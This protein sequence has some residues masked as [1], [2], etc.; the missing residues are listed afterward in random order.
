MRWN[1]RVK[2]KKIQHSRHCY[3]MS[4]LPETVHVDS[5]R[6]VLPVY[7]P[8]NIVV[9]SLTMDTSAPPPPPLPFAPTVFEHNI[10]MRSMATHDYAIDSVHVQTDEPH[11]DKSTDFQSRSDHSQSSESAC[12]TVTHS[13]SSRRLAPD[14]TLSTT[15]T[16]SFLPLPSTSSTSSSTTPA[17][18]PS[19][20]N[21]RSTSIVSSVPMEPLFEPRLRALPMASQRTCW[22]RLLNWC[23]PET[24][25]ALRTQMPHEDSSQPPYDV[26][27]IHTER[28][29]ITL[30]IVD[31]VRGMYTVETTDQ[32]RHRRQRNTIQFICIVYLL[33]MVVVMVAIWHLV[34]R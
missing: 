16:H 3:T 34:W 2:M 24:T 14:I 18:P 7:Y 19:Y 23:I 33:V 11:P 17:T 8:Q 28:D 32:R 1:R 15:S 9:H 13:V 20:Q 26:I 6:S 22:H 5:I 21:N 25:F 10:D 29:G 12:Q 31:P 30:Q 4:D 27:V